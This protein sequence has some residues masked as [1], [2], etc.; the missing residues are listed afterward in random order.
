MLLKN[1]IGISGQYRIQIRN[2]GELVKDYIIDNQITD[3]YL[4]RLRDLAYGDDFTAQSPTVNKYLAIAVGTDG[5]TETGSS[6]QLG[7]EVFR[8]AIGTNR[9]KGTNSRVVV[10]TSIK[11][12]DVSATPTLQ[13]LG[14]FAQDT[15][16]TEGTIETTAD[17]GLLVSRININETLVSGDIL[18][19]SYTNTFATV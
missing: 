3:S 10:Y 5:T 19:I 8:N 6:T 15:T 9:E 1:G 11:Y 2:N 12:S 17:T 16:S 14:I 18:T 4:D 7:V 13:E